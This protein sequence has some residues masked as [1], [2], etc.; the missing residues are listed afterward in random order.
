VSF[1]LA[2]DKLAYENLCKCVIIVCLF[3]CLFILLTLGTNGSFYV[4]AFTVWLMHSLVDMGAGE[5][6]M[7]WM[8]DTR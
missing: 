8:L 7:D 3:S 2:S 6:V 4:D 5:T 1:Y